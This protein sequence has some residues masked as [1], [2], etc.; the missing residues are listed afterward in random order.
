MERIFG[1]A[2][3]YVGHESQLPNPG[4]YVTALVGCQPIIAIRQGDGSIHALY[5]R[6]GHRGARLVPDGAGSVRFFRCCYHGWTFRTDG[7]V[8]SIPLRRGY[9]GTSFDERDAGFSMRRAGRTDNYRG[10]IFVNLAADGPDLRDFLGGIASSLD[11]MVDR[12][13]GGRIVIS[14]HPFRVLQRSNWKLF[15]EN[16]NDAMHALSTHESSVYAARRALEAIADRESG[17]TTYAA[18]GL[19]AIEKNGIAYTTWDKTS[20]TV[21]RRGHSFMGGFSNPASYERDYVAALAKSAGSERMHAI[22]SVNRHNSIIFPSCALRAA[23]QQLRIIRPLAPDRTMIEVQNFTL[24]GAG[25]DAGRRGMGFSNLVNSPSSIVMADDL[26]A[27]N[28][29][30]DGLASA[31]S[32][33]ISLDRDFGRDREA[34]DSIS[35]PATSELPMR[36]QL[37]AWLEYMTADN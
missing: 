1:R 32:E 6:C 8:L 3:V 20:T 36:N 29:V 24:V 37:R 16:L 34:P 13:P 2:W 18:G 23:Y 11:D 17:R 14:G 4:D 30:Q 19:A 10:F 33:W 28:R 9:D 15:F 26:E 7:S 12:A 35:A 31:G 22:L 5:N 25:A 21:F 27:F